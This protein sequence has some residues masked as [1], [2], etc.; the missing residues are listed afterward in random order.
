M[1]IHLAREAAVQ[2][3]ADLLRQEGRERVEWRP[4]LFLQDHPAVEARF[5]NLVTVVDGE[6]EGDV[7]RH[8]RIAV[9]WLTSNA[10]IASMSVKLSMR[11]TS[12]ASMSVPEP[13]PESRIL[14]DALVLVRH[15]F[16]RSDKQVCHVLEVVSARDIE[17]VIVACVVRH[18]QKPSK[19]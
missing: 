13:E 10:L 11:M 7:V 6:D 12:S 17:P 18:I 15:T 1:G 8:P 16:G 9:R 3:P 5:A 14:A 19:T 4:P 2:E